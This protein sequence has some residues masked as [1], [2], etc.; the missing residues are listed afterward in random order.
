MSIRMLGRG[1]GWLLLGG[2]LGV[3]LLMGARLYSAEVGGDGPE[4]AYE[5]ISLFTR[6][7]EQVRANY[8]DP[9]KAGY[10]Q[11]IDGALNGMLQSLDPHCEFMD[12]ESY[13]AMKDDTSGQ[14]GG[15][16]IV[17]SVRD[18]LITVVAPM[19]DT[20]SYRAGMLSGDRII[21]IDGRLTER[22]DLNVAVK[23][24]RGAPGTSVNLKVLRPKTQEVKAFTLVREKI[25]I[26]SVKD[27]R[28]VADGVGYLRITQFAEPTADLLQKEI[29][30]LE[31]QG[32]RAL[33]ID[34]RDNPGGLL[35][36]AI[37]VSQK[38]LERGDE[39]VSTMGRAG[40]REEIYKV[41]S[42]RHFEFPLAILVNGGS[43]SASEIVAGALQDH[44]RAVLVGEKTFGKGSVQSVVPLDDG[45]AIRLTTAKYYTPSHRVIHEHGI[46]PD[47]V[48][49]MD[50]ADLRDLMTLSAHP[51]DWEFEELDPAARRRLRSVEDTQLQRAVEML[52]GVQ[53]F[54]RR[55]GK[56]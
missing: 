42:R 51:G 36:A 17:V 10:D 50:P 23:S 37:E 39:V 15:L 26:R 21:D 46:E 18:G 40:R 31:G 13:A 1:L 9:S 27:A 41:R 19:E 43:A 32:L 33:V 28:L 2:L 44:Q 52:Q 24:L 35:S 3:N 20:P 11:L 30:K 7:L 34:L 25:E 54:A 8:V 22:M 16:G 48:V 6:V 5:K 56:Q 47:V 55:A 14:F 49:A 53:A 29:E 38:F 4:D 12:L 45:T